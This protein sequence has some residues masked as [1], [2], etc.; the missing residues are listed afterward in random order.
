[1]KQSSRNA[2]DLIQKNSTFLKRKK[3]THSDFSLPSFSTLL[4]P[5]LLE[6]HHSVC[7][8]FQIHCFCLFQSHLKKKTTTLFCSRFPFSGFK[9]LEITV[10]IMSTLRGSAWKIKETL[11]EMFKKTETSSLPGITI[12]SARLFFNTFLRRKGQRSH[13]S[14]LSTCEFSAASSLFFLTLACYPQPFTGAHKAQHMKCMEFPHVY[15]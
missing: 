15:L 3:L 12:S 4:F 13:R 14:R 9:N 8:P 11:K 1:M 2:S 5:K 10:P 7:V 6:G